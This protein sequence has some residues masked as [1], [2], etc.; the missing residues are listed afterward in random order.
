MNH[1][2]LATAPDD[3]PG[4]HPVSAAGIADDSTKGAL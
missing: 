4:E 1:Q 2:L 3:P